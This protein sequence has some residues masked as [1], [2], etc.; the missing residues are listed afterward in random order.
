[1]RRLP[2]TFFQSYFSFACC[3]KALSDQPM[4]GCC[5]KQ[6]REMGYTVVVWEQ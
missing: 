4:I 5:L 2:N 1:L 3:S 6:W